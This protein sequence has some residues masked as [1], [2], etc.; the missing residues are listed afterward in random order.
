MRIFTL[1]LWGVLFVSFARAQNTS[2]YSNA[3]GSELSS[4]L[5]SCAYGTGIGAGIGVIS[6][7]L[8]DKPND[9]TGNIA[10]GA[11]LG[12]YGGIIYGL[13]QIQDQH[14]AKRAETRE[15]DVMLWP[16]VSED[17]LGAG[18]ALRF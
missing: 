15:I 13:L 6:L 10:R 4:F 17:A 12:L 11:S 16:A 1:I 7:S 3:S 8:E 2:A 14:K 9:H 18:F 5:K